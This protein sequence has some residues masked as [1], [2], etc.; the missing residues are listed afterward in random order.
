MAAGSSSTTD[1]KTIIRNKDLMERYD[2]TPFQLSEWRRDG[3]D[4]PRKGYSFLE[5]ALSRLGD[6]RYSFTRTKPLLTPK[7]HVTRAE[8]ADEL[9]LPVSRILRMI[10]EGALDGFGKYVFVESIETYKRDQNS[11]MTCAEA[12]RRWGVTTETIGSWKK[13]GLI[14][15]PYGHVYLDQEKPQIGVAF[16]VNRKRKAVLSQSPAR[17]TKHIAS[18]GFGEFNR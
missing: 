15:G 2:I 7:E 9:G 11:V 3:L 16:S 4:Q 18:P 10:Q 14:H 8:A 5:D 13:S 12:A 1:M 17:F 6:V